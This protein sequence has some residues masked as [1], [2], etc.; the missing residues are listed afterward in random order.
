VSEDLNDQGLQND[1]GSPEPSQNLEGNNPDPSQD[2]AD[3]GGS[4]DLEGGLPAQD[5]RGVPAQNVLSE[6]LRKMD[7]LTEEINT[8]KMSQQR[9]QQFREYHEPVQQ[10]QPQQQQQQIIPRSP[11][12]IAEIVEKESR[13]KFGQDFSEGK[14]DYWEISRFQNKRLAE[15]NS[16]MMQNINSVQSERINSEARIKGVY[17]DLNNHQSPLSQG[18]FNEISRRAYMSGMSPENYYK[19]NPYVLES[20]APLVANNLGITPKVSGLPKIQQKQNNNLPPS[21]FEGRN[22]VHKGQ[23]KPTQE[24]VL[25]GKR[26]GV[27][28]ETL[29]KVRETGDPTEFIDESNILLS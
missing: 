17:A 29:A 8:M 3:Q 25:L 16:I 10:R 14:A 2:N 6:M 20:V 4:Q 13:E 19:Q 27:K 12:E 26:F 18:V 24:D 11:E 23:I 15:L 28:A 7:K 1:G 5:N 22:S 21:N 9:P